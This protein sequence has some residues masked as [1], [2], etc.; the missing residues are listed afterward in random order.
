MPVNL[1]SIQL[2]N[3]TFSKAEHQIITEPLAKTFYNC[4]KLSLN[5]WK[6]K[7]WTNTDMLNMRLATSIK[8][9]SFTLYSTISKHCQIHLLMQIITT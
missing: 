3:F 2:Q 9:T 6:L 4:Q 1:I 8:K 5:R 7:S